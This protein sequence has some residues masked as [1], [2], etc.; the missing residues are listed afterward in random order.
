[1][2]QLRSNLAEVRNISIIWK[3]LGGTKFPQ[4]SSSLAKW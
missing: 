1:L 2:G 4:T 3:N